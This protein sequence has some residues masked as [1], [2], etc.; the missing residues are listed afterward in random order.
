MIPTWTKAKISNIKETIPL[1]SKLTVD[2]FKNSFNENG[3]TVLNN[4]NGTIGIVVRLFGQ[5]LIDKYFEKMIEE[6]LNNFGISI[7]L[8]A[9]FEQAEASLMNIEHYNLDITS[10]KE[11]V[12]RFEEEFRKKQ[13][14]IVDSDLIIDFTPKRHPAVCI[15]R[16]VC[17]SILEVY[18]TSGSTKN[19]AV[20]SFIKEFNTNIEGRI[21]SSFGEDYE[22]HLREVDEKWT[23]STEGKLL[24]DMLKLQRIGFAENEDLKYQETFA[25][26]NK[27]DDYRNITDETNPL[28]IQIFENKLSP[29]EDLIREYFDKDEET[30]EKTLFI[31]ADFG[32]GKSVFLKQKAYTLAKKYEQYG[33]GLIPIYFNLRDFD[34]YDQSSTFGIISD[35]LGKKYGIDV[36]KE[37]FQK[38][39]YCFL[40]DSLDECG[41]LT[42]ERID[43]VLTS[44]K[45][46]QNINITNCRHNRLIITSRPIEHGLLKHLNSGKPYII[47]NSEKR[48]I[49]YYISIYGFKKEQFNDS[50]IDSLRNALPLDPNDFT[51]ISKKI[52]LSVIHEHEIDIYQEFIDI[53][54]LT[55]SELRRPIF[56]YMIYKLIISKANLSF[57]NKVGVFLSFINVLTKEAKYIDDIQDIN[58]R[59]E[60][61]FRNILHST[62]A[63]WMY[64]N[65]KSNQGSLKKQDISN[66][67]E[68]AII[69][70]N[71]A[72]TL[73]K[74]EEV[75]NVEFLSQSYFGQKGDTFYF[76]H[77][78]FAEI[79]LAEYY[80]KLFIHY[81]LD[82]SLRIDD[83][84]VR[85]LLGNPTE[86]TI[87]FLIGLLNLL[88]ESVSEKEQP[89]QSIIQKR[90]LL[91]PML[92][93][94]CTSDYSKGLYSQELKFTWFNNSQINNNTTEPPIDLLISWAITDTVIDK[95]IK[96]AYNIINSNSRYLLAKVNS[97][98]TSLYNNEVIQLNNDISNIPPDI[99]RWISFLIGNQLFNNEKEMIFFSANISETKIIFDMMKNWNFFLDTSSP[100]W[101]KNLFKGM[102]MRYEPTLE[103]DK[104]FD[105]VKNST[106][107]NSIEINGM[108]FNG[109]DFSFSTLSS[110]SFNQ[111]NFYNS[112]FISAKLVHVRFSYSDFAEASFRSS[113][114]IKT[115]FSASRLHSIDLVDIKFETLALDICEILQGVILPQSLTYIL[116]GST[117]GLVNFGKKSYIGDLEHD[118][119]DITKEMF[120]VLKPLIKWILT[121]EHA[122]LEEVKQW[123]IFE[124]NNDKEIFHGLLDGI[125]V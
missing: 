18:T 17:A 70:K 68:G 46:I 57:S 24:N 76:Q 106:Q 64:E 101:G 39:R 51:D 86:Q 109:M 13:D 95:I 107:G 100:A 105:I 82:E 103:N 1:I 30:I 83:V 59:D 12:E 3:Q 84:R 75:V 29:I 96:L 52:V 31:L 61:K 43:R 110:L 47:N 123:F 115:S 19:E 11:I 99:D 73:R 55:T 85:L 49:N 111:C 90:K 20:D 98:H 23:K 42:E 67:I 125:S 45:K 88:R 28:H 78:S 79:L 41:N 53:D 22:R 124:N 35:Y 40:V 21:I 16:E 26:W 108:D 33:D 116:K 25:Y 92:A 113:T 8:K 81:A 15:V 87:D 66:T 119:F 77:Q 7:Y 74:Y 32:K 71:D 72:G 48:P 56:N 122:K 62:A 69:D 89:D 91:F 9:A 5:Q 2:N 93:S 94:L 63:L 120:D 97:N 36:Q 58:L 114:F 10:R 6:K 117:S 4:L 44:I 14:T 54:L 38:N 60:Y 118:P 65:H 121:N 80:L 34:K 112:S 104:E 102:N 27:V 37:D 50:L